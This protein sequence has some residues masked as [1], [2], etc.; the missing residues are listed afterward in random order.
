MVELSYAHSRM[1]R[2]GVAQVLAEKV[3]AGFCTEAE[4]VGWRV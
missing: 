1:A 3:S 2:A 4:A